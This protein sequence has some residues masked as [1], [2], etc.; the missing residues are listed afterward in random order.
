MARNLSAPWIRKSLESLLGSNASPQTVPSSNNKICQVICTYERFRCI[1][2]SD[3]SHYIPLFLNERALERLK[4]SVDNMSIAQLKDC[5][6]RVEGYFFT[7]IF[8]A[9]ADRDIT[10]LSKS[11]HGTLAVQCSGISYLGGNDITTF[12]APLDVN[13]ELKSFIKLPGH[14][15]IAQ[16]LATRQFPNQ[17]CLPDCGKCFSVKYCVML[18]R[19]SFSDGEFNGS[20]VFSDLNPLTVVDCLVSVDQYDL[21]D[22]LKTFTYAELIEVHA[23]RNRVNSFPGSQ[24][25][26]FDDVLTP[27]SLLEPVEVPHGRKHGDDVLPNPL[28]EE[29]SRVAVPSVFSTRIPDFDLL[30]QLPLSQE[31]DFMSQSQGPSAVVA[32]LE[33]DKLS[34]QEEP[35]NMEVIADSL[36]PPSP[37]SQ[38]VRNWATAVE[39]S[40]ASSSKRKQPQASGISNTTTTT[41]SRS[42]A[43]KYVVPDRQDTESSTPLGLGFLK[44]VG[45]ILEIL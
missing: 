20:V 41:D 1:A 24:S 15:S 3:G 23:D 2:I 33:S 37:H 42:S 8:Q 9:A 43:M 21:I 32:D 40:N 39:S 7:T 27:N 26:Q 5:L 13:K 6:I 35:M 4:S 30:T 14:E 34:S 29:D 45:R 44:G 31:M 17:N 28:R 18:L 12:G 19:M 10:A 25:L 11:F 36:L 22:R 16:R 38:N